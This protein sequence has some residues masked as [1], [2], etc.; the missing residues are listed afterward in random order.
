MFFKTVYFR[1]LLCCG[2]GVLFRVGRDDV[3]MSP[4]RR[5]DVGKNVSQAKAAD[6]GRMSGGLPEAF[7]A[8]EERSDG[9]RT[10]G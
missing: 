5:N 8:A 2:T 10:K 1:A 4:G 3:M 7:F 9:H 6:R